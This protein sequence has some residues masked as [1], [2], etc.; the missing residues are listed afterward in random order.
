[1]GQHWSQSADK[2]PDDCQWFAVITY[3]SYESEPKAETAESWR[4]VERS[5]IIILK[6]TSI[7]GLRT[8][9]EWGSGFSIA[10]SYSI[11]L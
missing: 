5:A 7:C 6:G 10:S 9:T 3:I 11:I 4:L 8:G 1:M 2:P